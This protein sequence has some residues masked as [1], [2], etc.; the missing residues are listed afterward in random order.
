[1]SKGNINLSE[2]SV[3]ISEY[4]EQKDSELVESKVLGENSFSI[5]E[6]QND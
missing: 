3:V 5:L 6:E 1:M 4:F 2:K